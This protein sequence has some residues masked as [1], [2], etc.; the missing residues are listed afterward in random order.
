MCYRSG[1]TCACCSSS[2]NV[3]IC[4]SACSQTRS[5]IPGRKERVLQNR[6]RW[7]GVGPGSSAPGAEAVDWAP[8]LPCCRSWVRPHRMELAATGLLGTGTEAEVD[9]EWKS[10]TSR[11]YNRNED[12]VFQPFKYPVAVWDTHSKA[13][14]LRSI[15]TLELV[16]SKSNLI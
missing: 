6:R 5:Q 4:H 13:S 1:W 10:R 14:S 16:W 7:R 15:F 8:C 3:K 11:C 12:L 9:R 2:W